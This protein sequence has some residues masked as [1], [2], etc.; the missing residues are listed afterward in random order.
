MF[1]WD[2]LRYLLAVARDG[3]TLAAARTL[4][5]NQST[6]HRRITELESRVGHRLVQ[7]HS[8]GYRLT[9]FGEQLIVE[10]EGVERAVHAVE[11]RIKAHGDDLVDTIR[12]TCPEPLAQ[13]ITASP[14][15]GLFHERH[16]GLTVEI[17]MSDGYLD[18]ARGDADVALRSGE[19]DD[20]SLVGRKIADSVW[21]VYASKVYIQRHGTPARIDDLKNHAIIGFQGALANHRAAKWLAAFAPDARIAATNNSVLGVLHA[22]K[23]GLGLA[24]LP[25]TIAAME[26]DLV[27]VLPPVRELQR[28]WFIL[29]T[30]ELRKTPRVAAFFD[31]VVERLD[32]V[33]PILMG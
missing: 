14:L 7:R 20:E 8:S 33:R 28:G 5:V 4:K 21:A 11:R 25:T 2:D 18:L 27:Q 19:P 15:F 22:V 12:L 17:V 29:T 31:F 10:A 9:S 1:L 23:S 26:S 16:P 24:P 30:P 3:S 32:I 13:R 6:V